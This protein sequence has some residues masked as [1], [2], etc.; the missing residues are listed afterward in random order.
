MSGPGSSFRSSLLPMVVA[1]D[2]RRYVNANP[3]AC[4]LLRLPEATVL[5]LRVDDLT[6][7]EARGQMDEL[8]ATFLREGTQRGTFELQ[9]PDGPRLAVEYSATAHVEPGRHLSILMFPPAGGDVENE[10]G[11]RAASTELLTDREREVLNLVAMGMGSTWIA[12]T[13]GVSTSTVETH[14]RHCLVKLHARNRA[15][16]IALGVR[17]GEIRLDLS[18]GGG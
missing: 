3:A 4:L 2:E 13:L 12:S 15:H 1:D 18:D 7:A 10:P 5:R 17:R 9:M 16:A 14:V 6:P 11:R 8:W